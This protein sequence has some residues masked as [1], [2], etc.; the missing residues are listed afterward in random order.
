VVIC[1]DRREATLHISRM[2]KIRSD[3][4]R[5]EEGEEQAD[6]LTRRCKAAT[7]DP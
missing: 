6:E 3:R 1:K 2:V 4:E 7:S 5:C